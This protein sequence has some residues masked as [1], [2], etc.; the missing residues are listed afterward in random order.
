MEKLLFDSKDLISKYLKDLSRPKDISVMTLKSLIALLDLESNINVDKKMEQVIKQYTSNS[1]QSR[2]DEKV[3]GNFLLEFTL[4]KKNP[5]KKTDGVVV[6]PTEEKYVQ[7]SGN[8]EWKYP[9]NT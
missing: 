3:L 8:Q 7:T 6:V 4:L 2:H 1:D 9:T 5:T